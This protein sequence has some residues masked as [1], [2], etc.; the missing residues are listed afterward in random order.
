MEYQNYE[1]YMR[2]ILGYSPQSPNIYEAYQYANADNAYYRDEYQAN[3]LQE[4]AAKEL[5][6]DLYNKINP[7]IC[8]VCN[9]NTKPITKELL[10]QMTEEVYRG[11]YGED[12]VVNVNVETARETTS[13]ENKTTR[14]AQPNT[15]DRERNKESNV[16]NHQSH[17]R[18]FI[19]ILILKHLL[20]GKRPP[21]RPPRP[22]FPGGPGMP[23]PPRPNPRPP[24][25]PRDYFSF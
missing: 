23:P 13:S 16:R 14:R 1:E 4:E 11:I 17:L 18:D 25:G 7:I 15:V 8:K 5:Y 20:G 6:P 21:V 3:F 12:T 10:E 19:K 24:I 9:T 2:Q 22:P